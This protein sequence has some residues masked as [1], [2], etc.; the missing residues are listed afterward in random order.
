MRLLPAD[1]EHG[2]TP[3]AW[4]AYLT[5]FVV[6][7][8]LARGSALDWALTA[9]ATSVFLALYFRGYWVQGRALL[10]IIAAITLLAVA[11]L[12]FNA[13]AGTLAVYATA[14]AARVGSRRAAIV[15]ILVVTGAFGVAAWL[16]GT[17]PW[18][19]MWALVVAPLVGMV[20]IH[21][22]GVTRTYARLRVAQEE[23]AHL[24]KLA[25]R[26]RIARDLHDV[27]GHTLSLIVLKSE[28]AAKLAEREPARAVQEIR[29]VE[30]ISREALAEVRKAVGGYRAGS[31]QQELASARK[32][33][34]SA[35]LTVETA[36]ADVKLPPGHEAVLSLVL[37]EAVTNIIRHARARSCRIEVATVGERVELA[38][39]DDGRGSVAPEGHGLQGM[40][41][42]I[43]ALGG[44]LT[45]D[46]TGGTHLVAS[47]PVPPPQ[48]HEQAEQA[49]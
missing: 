43:E 48:T 45:R 36:V 29:E 17:Y 32:T 42:R 46:G 22:A 5:Y 34:E 8:L 19:W 41:E 44:T 21:W 14:F 13:G 27:L 24:A 39:S 18:A 30:A 2:W 10:A 47:L 9:A 35:G 49:P 16:T 40:R 23:V 15:T 37:R 20:N 26:E 38:V 7:P 12:P 4:L 6:Y 1:S 11:C 31:L 25:E 28:L 3:Y 33:L